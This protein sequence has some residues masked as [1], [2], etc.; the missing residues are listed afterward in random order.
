MSFESQYSYTYQDSGVICS[1]SGMAH[2]FN[3]EKVHSPDVQGIK[4]NRIRKISQHRRSK[5]IKDLLWLV[6]KAK[7]ISGR[8]F[9]SMVPLVI[10]P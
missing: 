1:D 10:L 7:E 6:S 9:G 3:G 2:D 4:T 5:S 8:M